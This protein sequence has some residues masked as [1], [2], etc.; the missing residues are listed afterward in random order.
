MQMSINNFVTSSSN[1]RETIQDKADDN[2]YLY[3]CLA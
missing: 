3:K 2:V 1:E